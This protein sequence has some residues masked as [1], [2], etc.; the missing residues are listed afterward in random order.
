[1]KGD[2]FFF[3]LSLFLGVRLPACPIPDVEIWF[4]PGETHFPLYLSGENLKALVVHDISVPEVTE[5]TSAHAYEGRFEV[6]IGERT[7]SGQNINII[8]IH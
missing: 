5:I 8:Q 1:M 3:L 2:S 4:Q 6:W 7:S